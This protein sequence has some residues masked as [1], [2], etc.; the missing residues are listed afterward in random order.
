MRAGLLILLAVSCL[1]SL[2]GCAAH[3]TLRYGPPAAPKV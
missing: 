3:N 1:P 2:S